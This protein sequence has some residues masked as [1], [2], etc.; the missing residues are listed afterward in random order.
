VSW[1]AFLAAEGVEAKAVWRRYPRTARLALFLSAITAALFVAMAFGPS[2]R[3]IQRADTAVLSFM[4]RV[5]WTPVTWIGLAFNVVGSVY[6]TAPVRVAAGIFAVVKRRWW[7]LGVLLLTVAS[8]E[9]LSSVS[10]RAYDRPR[11][12]GPLVHTTGASFPSGHAVATAST[13]IA[14][15]ILLVE[16]GK[17]AKWWIGTTLFTL[18]MA[19]SRAYLHAHWLSDAVAGTLLGAACGLDS[20]LLL[21][22]IRDAVARQPRKVV[23]HREAGP[24][25]ESAF[26]DGVYEDPQASSAI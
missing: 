3:V 14:L 20:A 26:E 25:E 23:E 10:K 15:V 19:I 8:S 11:P 22:T 5:R 18:V 7:L 16:P 13:A 9:F 4:I 12:P 21:Q 6:V 17:R 1:P 2:S 24:L